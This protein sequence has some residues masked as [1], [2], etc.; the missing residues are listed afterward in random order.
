MNIGRKSL[1][2]LRKKGRGKRIREKKKTQTTKTQK[3]Y[4]KS[5]K[6]TKENEQT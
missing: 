5:R 2:A 6:L 1:I 4:Q 3:N